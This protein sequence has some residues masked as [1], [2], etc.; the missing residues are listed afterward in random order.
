MREGERGIRLLPIALNDARAILTFLAGERLVAAEAFAEK[1]QETWGLLARA[2]QL[3]RICRDP[4]L[5]RKGYR[6]LVVREYLV[7]YV[8]RDDE[9]VVH[10]I[11]HGARNYPGLF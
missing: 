6:S 2:P 11:L 7:F 3:G 8:V 5:S 1:L 10:R 9:V 4:G